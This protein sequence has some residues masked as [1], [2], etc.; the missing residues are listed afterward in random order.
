MKPFMYARAAD[1][2]AAV[3]EMQKSAG[4]SFI[5]GGTNL[6]DLM[7]EGVAQPHRLID[8]GRLALAAITPIDG[9]G[10]RLGALARNSDTANHP[11]VRERFPLVSQAILSGASG[12]L[13]NMATNGGNLMQRTRCPYFYDLASPCNKRTPGSGCSALEGVNKSHAILGTSEHCIATHPSD[14]CVALVALDAVVRVQGPTGERTIPIAEFHR[15]P[16]ATPHVETSLGPTELIT[17]IDLP[18]GP[19][20]KNW[21]YVK[22]RERASYAF[23][24][25]A[26]AV[27]LEMDGDTI[28][29]AR[30]ALGGVATKPWR[31]P[32]AERTLAGA[33]AGEAAFKAAADVALRD[34]KPRRHNQYKV[35]LAHRLLLRALTLAAEA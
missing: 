27:A 10:L 11:M 24:L 23:A 17:A 18:A 35:T 3:A 20:A 32:D 31:V 33:K 5:A 1:P 25:A 2:T 22:V 9:G 19:Y 12:Q 13:R 34:A 16:G 14:F 30:V 6:V 7:K 28:K 15:L 21:R 29:S 26:A 8:V 4:S